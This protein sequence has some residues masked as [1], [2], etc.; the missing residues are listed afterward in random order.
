ML[1]SQ[2]VGTFEQLQKVS[3][4]I[5]HFQSNSPKFSQ[6]YH[7]IFKNSTPSMQMNQGGT[8]SLGN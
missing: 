6:A 5:F 1:L 7:I 2:Y 4:D 8:V 3:V